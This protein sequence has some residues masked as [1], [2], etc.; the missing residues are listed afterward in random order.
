MIFM[1]NKKKLQCIVCL[2]FHTYAMAANASKSEC[3]GTTAHG[4]LKNGVA[5]P[6]EGKNFISYSYLAQTLGRTY[7]HSKVNE[8]VIDS[9]AALAQTLP[10]KKYKYAETGFKEGGEFSPHK[11]HQ[12]GLSIDFMVPVTDASGKPAYFPTHPLNKFG[13]EVEFDATGHY[14]SYRI[15]FEAMAAHI[16]QLHKSAVK[17]GAG[18][19]RVIFDP[20][21]QHYLLNTQ[22]GPYI[23]QHIKLSTKKSWVRHDEHYHVDF[24]VPCKPLPQ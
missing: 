21:L 14:E 8:I 17:A 3:Y 19:W 11:T 10:A 22:E 5:L 13:Y 7:V 18:I 2:I 4:S 15:D 6:A 24:V 20:P 9:Y 23:K 12:N 16:V 1:N